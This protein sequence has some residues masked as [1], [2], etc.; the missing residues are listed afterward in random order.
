MTTDDIDKM[1]AGPE[2]DALVA[3][4]VMKIEPPEMRIGPMRFGKPTMTAQWTPKPY[5]THILAAWEVIEKLQGN[6]TVALYRVDGGSVIYGVKNKRYS[7]APTA[8]L[9]ICRA[10][11]KAVIQ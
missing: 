8:P 3:K 2:M 5:S 11:L 7:E 4:R 10:A 9:A 6:T 1:E